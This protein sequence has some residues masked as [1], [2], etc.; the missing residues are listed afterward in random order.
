M[1]EYLKAGAAV[2]EITPPGTQFL[3]GYPLAPRYSA[4][5]HDPL[6]SSALYLSDGVHQA[7]FI[8]ND[9]IWVGKASTRRIRERIEAATS[10]PAGSVMVTATHTH[11][12]PMTLDYISN[13]AD[14]A[15]PKTDP[16]Y[17]RFMEDRIVTAGVLAFQSAQPAEAGL[18][19]ARASGVGTNRRA[20]D[21]PSDSEVPVL[22]VRSRDTQQPLA[23][24]I[25]YSMHPTVLH[26]DSRQIS[27]D[28]PG[29]ARL[30]LQRELFGSRL[31]CSLPHG[32][33]GEPE[34]SSRDPVQHL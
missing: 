16:A 10:V 5:V 27:G 19:M 34:P 31:S 7:I 1:T 20:P 28:F 3:Y 24:M 25:V 14:D 6:L 17:V 4:G 18:G 23:C 2:T 11:S 12:G 29:L 32:A 30:Y 13:E 21:G 8:A 33:G 9:I 15:V 26:E 22:M